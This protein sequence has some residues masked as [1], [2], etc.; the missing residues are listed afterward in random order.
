VVLFHYFL[1]FPQ[2][3][4]TRI[5]MKLLKKLLVT[6]AVGYIAINCL[7]FCIPH[8]NVTFINDACIIPFKQNDYHT[9]APIHINI[10]GEIYVVPQGFTTDLASIPKP[11]WSFIAPQFTSYVAPSIL[12][13]YLYGC[14]NFF[15]RKIDDEIFYSALISNDVS[16]YTAAKFY[17]AVRFFGRKHFSDYSQICTRTSF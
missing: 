16:R 10:D 14:S 7:I 2:V 4:P 12:H 8:H 15:N 17:L 3:S 5:V 9:C 1:V 11:L 6:L 13:D